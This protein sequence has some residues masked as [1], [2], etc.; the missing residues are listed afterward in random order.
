[1]SS[2]ET[3][4][5]LFDIC[6]QSDNPD[7]I[8]GCLNTLRDLQVSDKVTLAQRLEAQLRAFRN[9]RI[10]LQNAQETQI[11]EKVILEYLL[12]DCLLLDGPSGHLVSQHRSV[13]S[14]WLNDL[15]DAVRKT[16]RA[17][18]LESVLPLL[19]T[20]TPQA[21]CWVISSI[22]YRDARV[23]QS[24]WKLIHSDDNELGDIALS[25]IARLGISGQEKDGVVQELHSR[26]AKRYNNHLLWGI[27]RLGDASRCACHSRAMVIFSSSS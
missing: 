16:I 6:S 8:L 1:M 7:E 10:L 3:F 22:G 11:T 24:L 18:A 17:Q 9:M 14:E 26:A 23:V 15:E 13:L 25:T 19:E 20:L 5:K 21:A 27:A 4:D 2:E 12:P